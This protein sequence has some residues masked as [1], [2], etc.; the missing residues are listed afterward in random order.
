M[1]LEKLHGL[2]NSNSYRKSVTNTFVFYS[3]T[4]GNSL[5]TSSYGCSNSHQSLS[6]KGQSHDFIFIVPDGISLSLQQ[7]VGD[8]VFGCFCSSLMYAPHLGANVDA[9]GVQSHQW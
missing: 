8:N 1:V 2:P 3:F 7:L 6:K 9:P 4:S 5:Q